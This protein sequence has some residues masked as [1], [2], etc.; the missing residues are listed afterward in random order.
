M[1][2]RESCASFRSMEI[3]SPEPPRE[4]NIPVISSDEERVKSSGDKKSKKLKK[5]NNSQEF[6]QDGK[7]TRGL[8]RK[9]VFYL[10]FFLTV[11]FSKDSVE[12]SDAAG[13]ACATARDSGR[14]RKT[15]KR[16]CAGIL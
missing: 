8:G 7:L 2:G 14:N 4:L 10:I 3:L 15:E 6:Q 5:K 11:C 13:A 1:S 9:V 12:R 16:E